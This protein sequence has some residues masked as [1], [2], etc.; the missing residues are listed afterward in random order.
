MK[1]STFADLSLLIVAFIWGT[2][3]VLVQNAISTME[4][5][6]FN[7]FRF[8]IAFVILFLSLLLFQRKQLQFL[9]KR[10]VISGFLLGFWLFLGYATQTLGLL[11]TTSS[12]A[13]FITGLSVVLVPF[14]SFLLLKQKPSFPAVIG[15][16]IATV[17]LF[18]LTMT[19]IA[20]LNIG[21]FFVLICA[22]GFAMHIIF[23]GKYS[24]QFPTLLL[25]TIQILTVSILSMISSFIFEDFNEMLKLSIISSQSVIIALIVTSVFA[26]ALA[27]FAQTSF[28]KYTTPTRV[29]LIFAME[30]VFAAIA[31]YYWANERLSISAIMGCLFIFLGMVFAELPVERFSRF[32]NKMASKEAN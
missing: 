22:F 21:D 6:A 10:I 8:F 18:L 31:G 32:R 7:S 9:S 17:G 29:A 11:Y 19:D 3:F 12:K 24:E 28:Q 14:F 15:V 5:F 23:T 30:P 16:S 25:T 2:T 20:A 4:P 27:F 1:K 13:G 26:T